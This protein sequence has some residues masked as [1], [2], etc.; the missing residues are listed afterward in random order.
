MRME[1][2]LMCIEGLRMSKE[3]TVQVSVWAVRSF[4]LCRSDCVVWSELKWREK[5]ARR[6]HS[7]GRCV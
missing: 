3:G 2:V 6:H 7:K 1:R 4:E 5:V